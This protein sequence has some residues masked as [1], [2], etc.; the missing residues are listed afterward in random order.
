[1]YTLLEDV[2]KQERRTLPLWLSPTQARLIPIRTDDV[3]LMAYANEV[4]TTLTD[5]KI[6]VDIDDRAETL[7]W[8]IRRGRDE[9]VPYLCVLGERER[10]ERVISVKDWRKDVQTTM[11]SQEFVELV[12]TETMDRQY[13]PLHDRYLTKRVSFR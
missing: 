12:R 2:E 6:R 10:E 3:A 1:M 8:R 11:T 5:K 4:A 9:W 13:L 7:S